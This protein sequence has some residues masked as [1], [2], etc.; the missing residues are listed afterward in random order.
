MIP[1]VSACGVGIAEFLNVFTDSFLELVSAN[2]GFYHPE[3]A[4]AFAV[5]NFVKQLLDLFRVGDS[6]LDRMGTSQPVSG[7]RSTG[8][9]SYKVLPD[10][11]SRIGLVDCLVAHERCEAFV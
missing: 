10:S 8:L 11:P 7:H 2:V 6:G 4:G 9:G 3:D 5:T 1:K